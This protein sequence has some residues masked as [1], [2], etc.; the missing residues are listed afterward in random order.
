VTTRTVEQIA[1]E[2]IANLIPTLTQL[3]TDQPTTVELEEALKANKA[4]TRAIFEW[5]ASRY[6]GQ[7]AACKAYGCPVVPVESPEE[8]EELDRIEHAHPAV[9]H[10]VFADLTNAF[11]RQRPA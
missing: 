1:P 8:S 9:L 5:L 4:I 6:S 7:A 3:T 2:T 10:P 11:T